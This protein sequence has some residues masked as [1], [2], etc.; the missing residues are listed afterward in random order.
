MNVRE[1]K[2]PDKDFL[3]W[4]SWLRTKHCLC[5]DTGSI[6]GLAPWV[7]NPVAESYGI[8]RR[9]SLDLWL[10]HK[11]AAADPIQPLAWELL[12]A[13]RCSIKK[14]K[15]SQTKEYT[16]YNYIYMKF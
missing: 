5:E 4:L 3:L 13:S 14:K 6:P 8:D 12:Y 1:W 15:K 2:K 16:L 11:P 7:K 9:C 10:W